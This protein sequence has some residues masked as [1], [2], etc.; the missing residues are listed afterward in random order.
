[1]SGLGAWSQMRAI[2]KGFM[3]FDQSDAGVV[4]QFLEDAKAYSAKVAQNGDKPTVGYPD[5]S[6]DL[7]P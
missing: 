7:R 4:E 5:F 2:G 1:M 3:P 6:G